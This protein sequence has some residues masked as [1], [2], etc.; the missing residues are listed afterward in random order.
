M[1]LTADEP[2]E[3]FHCIQTQYKLPENVEGENVWLD[4]PYH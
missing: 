1:V 3:L 2:Q 4:V